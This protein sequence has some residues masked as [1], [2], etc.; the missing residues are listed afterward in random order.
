MKNMA[1]KSEIVVKKWDFRSKKQVI[2]L[3]KIWVG[4][5]TRKAKWC[6]M[7]A[8]FLKVDKAKGTQG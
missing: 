5:R 3:E 8:L 2:G 4:N 1:E 7:Q 6:K